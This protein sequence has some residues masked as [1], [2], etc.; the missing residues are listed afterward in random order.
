R[1]SRS[2]TSS[3]V[4]PRIARTVIALPPGWGWEPPRGYP[5]PGTSQ[6]HGAHEAAQLVPVEHACGAG[7]QPAQPHG[8]ELRAHE[9]QHRV[10]DGVEHTPDDAVAAL[11]QDHLD[12]G[13]ARRGVHDP[14]RVDTDRAVVELDALP[15]DRAERGAHP[16]ADGRQV[17]RRGPLPRGGEP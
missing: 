3:W 11:V 10:A 14:E 1:C 4:A 17:G 6:A 16:A 15:P 2:S 9:S 8:A 12:H 13:P 5:P 7:P